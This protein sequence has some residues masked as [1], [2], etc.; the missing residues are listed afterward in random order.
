[1]K[2]KF[3]IIFY[4]LCIGH[5]AVAEQIGNKPDSTGVQYAASLMMNA[6][7]GNF[8]PYYIASNRHGVVTQQAG[9]QL[10]LSAEKPLALDK[11]FSWSAG[12]DFISGITSQTDYQRYNV[13]SE[14]WD[15]NKQRP[16]SI[17]L[18][19]LYG[20]LKWRQLFLEIGMKE[21]ESALFNTRLGSG[22]YV[23]SGNSRP[24]PG[25]RVGFI[26]FQDIPFTKGWLQIQGEIA[27][28]Q[29][30]DK[31]W[32]QNHYNY[33]L[34][35]I[36][37]DSWYHYKRLYFRTSPR[38]P[39]SV[40]FG[41]QTAAQFAGTSY[42]YNKGVVSNVT[43]RKFKLRDLWDMLI[44]KGEDT[45]YKGNHLGSWDLKAVY[46]FHTG[47]E[48]SAYFQWPWEDGS[49]IGKLNGFDGIWGI[50]WKK[51]EK[52]IISNVVAEYLTFMN[53]SGPLHY[54]PEDNYGSNLPAHT[55]GADDYYNNYQYNGYTHHGMGIGTP[56]LPPT[57]YN[58]DGY[59]QYVDT[60]LRGFHIGISGSVLTNLDYRL[61]GGYKEAFGSGYEPRKSPVHNTSLL[62]ETTWRVSQVPGLMLNAQIGIDRGNIYG[63]QCGALIGIV[64]NGFLN[65]RK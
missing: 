29:T 43:K 4:C 54:D 62:V 50:E 39:F 5:A 37:V 13:A 57:L 26:D 34:H 40:T 48:V 30:T 7:K 42:R 8:A 51:R 41:M 23:E 11:R 2:N 17:W 9:T 6:G 24:I 55:D 45:Y 33:Y 10:R 35:F 15:V 47:N 52:G 20:E 1:M 58:L 64:Y 19:Q 3:A 56:F 59:M 16:A 28:G 60:R 31:N 18:Q 32:L 22:D 49:G 12:V 14:K 65:F 63:N 44:T 36:T 38:Q 21:H 61:L 46:K 53:Q 25:V 27:Y